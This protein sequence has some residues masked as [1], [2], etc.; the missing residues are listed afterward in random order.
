[1]ICY[2]NQLAVTLVLTGV[3]IIPN[4]SNMQYFPEISP[5]KWFFQILVIVFYELTNFAF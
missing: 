3:N 5:L 1:M 4:K 2:G